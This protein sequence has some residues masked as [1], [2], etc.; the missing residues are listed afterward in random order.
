MNVDFQENRLLRTLFLAAC[1]LALLVFWGSSFPLHAGLQA[2]VPPR[3][4]A[5]SPSGCSLAVHIG[6][7]DTEWLQAEAE[8]QA[9]LDFTSPGQSISSLSL[10]FKDV[11]IRMGTDWIGLS[12]IHL[13]APKGVEVRS[14]LVYVQDVR[15]R[16]GSS[17][18]GQGSLEQTAQGWKGRFDLYAQ[19]VGQELSV[20]W[21]WLGQVDWSG[22][23]FQGLEI[24]LAWDDGGGRHPGRLKVRMHT[25]ST[26]QWS[27]KQ[28]SDAYI[29]P[30]VS[31]SWAWDL[32]SHRIHFD[33]QG[34]GSAQW[35]QFF[36][37][38]PQITG[39]LHLLSSGMRI[40]RA[41][42]KSPEVGIYGPDFGGRPV[43]AVVT[44]MR[45][46]QKGMEVEEAVC[47]VQDVGGFEVSGRWGTKKS[48]KLA[49]RASELRIPGLRAWLSKDQDL[50]PGWEF[51]GRT[52]VQADVVQGSDGIV[53]SWSLDLQGAGGASPDGQIMAAGITGQ[54]QGKV[55]WSARPRISYA[56]DVDGG[57]A[58]WG[59]R[60]ADLSQAPVSLQGGARLESG[61][62]IEFT[63]LEVRAGEFLSL[64][65]HARV[66]VQKNPGQWEVRVPEGR[67]HL[68]PLVVAVQGLM[69]SGWEA[70]GALGWT[71]ALRSAHKGAKI[72][73]R[74]SGKGLSLSAP[75]AGV[76]LEGWEFDLPVSYV[77]GTR[78]AEHTVQD[79]HPWG[80]LRP[81]RLLVAGRNLDVGGS[82]IRLADNVFQLGKALSVR[83]KGFDA[84]LCGLHVQ[85]PWSGQWQGQGEFLLAGLRP[86][87]IVPLG[88]QDVGGLQGRLQV[89]ASSREVRTKGR[90]EG[91]LFGGRV[92]I[93]N[94]GCKRPL[95]SSRLSSAD[96]HVHGLDLEPLST[97]LGVGRIT[98][99]LNIA[100]Q[101]L[102]V[103]YGQPVRFHLRAESVP[104]PEESRRISLQAINSLSIIGT[105]QGLS[106]LGVSL[107]AGFFEQ[108]PYKRIGLS[109]VLAND[110]FSLNGLIRE[111][112]VEY[113]VRR[114]WTGINVVN[115]NANNMIAF[116]DMLK[117]L[118]RVF[119]QRP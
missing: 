107:Y 105:G 88:G 21:P 8:I 31:A 15:C 6:A 16:I 91:T 95:E 101:R 60:Y 118:E 19:G 53:G 66:D 99:R 115:T 38:K 40:P 33:L 54:G 67:V 117:R 47:R 35:G 55:V 9:E 45:F 111:D 80:T 113:I 52:D 112:G 22:D 83:G 68:G 62:E 84:R 81:G 96:V 86:S 46:F 70:E 75:D 17:Q 18:V 1:I 28:S 73:G 82:D 50:V 26:V 100:V 116:S 74:L 24:L 92:R 30:P 108:F 110:V 64:R 57:E 85:L 5:Q 10:V 25:Q 13:E 23:A 109:C 3:D 104:E 69:P 43:D 65:A 102:G 34:K 77:L 56:L 4:E 32:S 78:S 94:I 119:E 89:T 14:G 42:L 103:A 61:R 37:R 20:V 12:P 76:Q 51:Q 72:T 63:D 27:G 114:G 39:G 87:K 49:F 2:H 29:L 11:N 97:G 79:S 71:G 48:N 58:L 106:G 90:I 44:D 59:T 93:E 36:A 98:G 7:V 41:S